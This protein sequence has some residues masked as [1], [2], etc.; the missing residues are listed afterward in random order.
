MSNLTLEDYAKF[1]WDFGHSFFLET[2]KG[3]FI[4]RDPE[5]GGDN[6]IRR[7]DGAYGD[8]MKEPQYGRDKG[9]HVIGA[10]CGKDVRFI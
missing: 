6:T 8:W 7:F 2:A 5:Y 3:N 10:Y 9:V 1:T 4:W